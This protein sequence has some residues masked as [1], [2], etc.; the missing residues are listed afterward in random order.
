MGIVSRGACFKPFTDNSTQRAPAPNNAEQGLFKKTSVE[1][2]DKEC[3]KALQ[4]GWITE[5]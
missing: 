3:N 5:T 4:H 1:N 2:I